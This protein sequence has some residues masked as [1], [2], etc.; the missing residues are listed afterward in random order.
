MLLPCF[1]NSIDVSLVLCFISTNFIHILLKKIVS[2]RFL[3]LLYQPSSLLNYH[4]RLYKAFILLAQVVVTLDDIRTVISKELVI[5]RR[6]S[7]KF[8]VV[9]HCNIFTCQFAEPLQGL[10]SV[11]TKF[12]S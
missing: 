1:I 2:A 6:F 8:S 7:R 11:I 12:S 4:Q 3:C 5:E 10:I 9:F